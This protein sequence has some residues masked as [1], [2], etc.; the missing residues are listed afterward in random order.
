LKQLSVD[1]LVPLP[2]EPR[3]NLHLCPIWP[4]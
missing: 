2:P 3:T 4:D 1:P